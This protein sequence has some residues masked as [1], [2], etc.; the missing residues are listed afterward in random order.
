MKVDLFWCNHLLSFFHK[1]SNSLNFCFNWFLPYSIK[2][3][4]TYVNNWAINSWPEF[5]SPFKKTFDL[6][7]NFPIYHQQLLPFYV[8]L[9]FHCFTYHLFTEW[10]KIKLISTALKQKCAYF[11][12]AQDLPT[13]PYRQGLIPY[14]YHVPPTQSLFP[15]S[16]LMV[17]YLSVDNSLP[18]YFTISLSP[19]HGPP[20]QSSFQNNAGYIFYIF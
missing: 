10:F 11:W 16:G 13:Q 17:L 1:I 12:L 18:G 8:C 15:Q 7:W 4:L 19:S 2:K 20:T 6:E 5:H 3:C 14:P 9:D